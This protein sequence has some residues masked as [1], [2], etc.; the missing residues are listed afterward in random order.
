M[1]SLVLPKKIFTHDQR[2]QSSI[3]FVSPKITIFLIIPGDLPA[4]EE[5]R[6][7]KIHGFSLEWISWSRCIFQD[8]NN[9]CIVSPFENMFF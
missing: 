3:Q 2:W 1:M 9:Y 6:I 4:A 7:R 5:F 8:T